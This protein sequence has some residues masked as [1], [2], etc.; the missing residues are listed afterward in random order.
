VLPTEK[1]IDHFNIID[2]FKPTF[3]A[4]SPSA[5]GSTGNSHGNLGIQFGKKT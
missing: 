5:V 3:S 4:G 2:L 1:I